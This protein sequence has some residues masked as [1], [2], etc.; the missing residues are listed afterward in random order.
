MKSGENGFWVSNLDWME[1]DGTM[2][3]VFQGDER[4][5]QVVIY[6][7]ERMADMLGNAVGEFIDRPDA[8][9]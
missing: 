8:G 6:L 7:T 5:E 3:I 9:G 2:T 4:D 1:S